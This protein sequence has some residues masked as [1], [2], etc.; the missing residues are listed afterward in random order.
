[1]RKKAL[2]PTQIVVTMLNEPGAL[3]VDR[4]DDRRRRRQYRQRASSARRTGFPRTALRPQ[5][6]DIQHLNAILA[7]LRGKS[8]VSK[9][10]RL[11]G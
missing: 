4:N 8:V 10:E 9:V 6:R 1:M 3:G 7:Q 2:Y 11:S 5:V